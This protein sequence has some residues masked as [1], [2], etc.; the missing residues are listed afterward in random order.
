MDEHITRALAALGA[1]A[2]LAGFGL[3]GA[4]GATARIHRA[5]G[6]AAAMTSAAKPGAQLWVRRFAGPANQDSRAAAVQVSPGGRKV[7]VTGTS[8]AAAATIAY[9]AITGARLWLARYAGPG[10]K[11]ASASSVAV[12]PGGGRVFVAASTADAAGADYATIAYSAATGAPIWQALYNGPG[13]GADRAVSLAVSPDGR[14]VYVTGLSKGR[15]SGADYATVAYSAA[16]GKQL[17]VARLGGTGTDVARSVAVG[18]GGARVLVTGSSEG[19][20]SGADYATVAYNAATGKRQWVSRYNGPTRTEAASDVASS[21][22]VSPGGGIVFVTGTS[23]QASGGRLTA[24]A[25]IAYSAATGRRMWLTRYTGQAGD[26]AG[27]SMIAASPAGGVVL[28]TGYSGVVLSATNYATIAY[29]ALTGKRMWLRIYDGPAHS[30]D[31]ASSLAVSPGGSTVF[32][33]GLSVGGTPD[34]ATVAYRA[35]TGAQ[36]WARR[37]NGPANGEDFATSVAVGAGG[38]R[39]FVTGVSAE[40]R[41]VSDYLTIAYQAAS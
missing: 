7:F 5:A 23:S 11:G 4:S 35:A 12:S 13:N 22:A 37:Y 10:E 3:A 15:I 34:Y 24:A 18:P 29:N 19:R 36:L 25:T 1:G 33:T 40:S 14:T 41:A 30:Y 38:R 27:A 26:G 20:A 2:I 31:V 9:N 6:T 21:V 17:W 8:G 32:V 28:V 39:L 16:T